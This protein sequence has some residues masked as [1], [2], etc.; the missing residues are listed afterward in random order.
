MVKEF[1]LHKKIFDNDPILYKEASKMV[2]EE[3][4]KYWENKNANNTLEDI[5]RIF[6]DC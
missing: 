6:C 5:E 4:R 1:K 2:G 3:K